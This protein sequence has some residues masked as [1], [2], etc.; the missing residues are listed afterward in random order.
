MFIILTIAL[1]HSS[2]CRKAF[3]TTALRN[4]HEKI[5]NKNVDL[6]K[7]LVIIDGSPRYSCPKCSTHYETS[8][9]L[10]KHIEKNCR[11]SQKKRLY[12]YPCS[13]CLRTFTT[14]VQAANHLRDVH[15][16][17]IVNIENFCF[18]CNEEYS[19]YVNHVRSHSCMF[20]C[21]FCGSKFLTKEKVLRHEESKHSSE[22]VEDRPFKCPEKH[23]GT[24]FK[25]I[26]HLK[27]HQKAIH[28]QQEREFQCSYCEKKFGLRAHLT[29]HERQ[30]FTK[31]PCNFHKCERNF[32]KLSNLKEHLDRDHGIQE[33]YL[34]NLENCEERFKLLTQLK[35]HR[36]SEH[37]VGFNIKTYFENH[38]N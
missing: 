28:T 19:D 38:W 20:S 15:Q 31:F 36:K 17:Q 35:Q 29:V 32:K 11:L 23:C 16:I 27:S 24:S 4:D 21:N 13:K 12:R 25:N 7:H 8:T 2:I 3:S 18:E 37:Q 6:Q 9:L 1:T 26:H 10:K 14:K 30:H 22:T 34:C 33:I 5:H